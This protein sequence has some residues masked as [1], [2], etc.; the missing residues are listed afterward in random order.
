MGLSLPGL[1]SGL[2]TTSLIS[3]LMQVEAIPQTLLK[4]QSSSVQS[5]ISA[6]QG[7]NSKVA[8][9]ATVATA[10][11]KPDSLELFSAT[12]SSA[13]V[14]ATAA[15]GAAAGSIDV[16][17]GATAQAQVSVSDKVATWP[18]NTFTITS[19]AGTPTT[20]IA[21][22]TSLDDVA[23]AVNNSSAGVNV[24]KIATGEVDASGN[25]LFRLQFSAGATG[26]AAGFSV[27][28]NTMT[29]ITPPTDARVTLYAGTTAA[30]DITS[31]TNTFTNLLPGV[32]VNVTAASTSPVTI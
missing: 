18:V 26:T 12:S 21:A 15:S 25:A 30:Q 1:A 27:S 5:M 7:L 20:I 29:Q 31:A 9:L 23:T 17:V 22:S 24:L 32:T 11:G 4:N 14:T 13:G 8:S 16:V 2:D 19:A 3:Q 6:L 10:A 28:N